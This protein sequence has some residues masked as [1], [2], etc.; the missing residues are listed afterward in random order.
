MQY[1]IDIKVSFYREKH[2][3][4]TFLSFGSLYGKPKISK[5]S[6]SHVIF[7]GSPGQPENIM[8]LIY[9]DLLSYIL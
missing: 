8:F 2:F 9:Y 1:I 5:I 3:I 4:Y 6:S 7:S